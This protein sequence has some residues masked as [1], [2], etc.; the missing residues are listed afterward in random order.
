MDQIVNFSQFGLFGFFHWRCADFG[1][2]P[3]FA[4]RKSSHTT[5]WALGGRVGTLRSTWGQRS[6]S[7]YRLM[8][9]GIIVLDWA[10]RLRRRWGH[11][12]SGLQ[13]GTHGGV[14][15]G[16]TWKKNNIGTG[17]QMMKMSASHFSGLCQGFRLLQEY[18]YGENPKIESERR[19]F[20]MS[21][22]KAIKLEALKNISRQRTYHN[23]KPIFWHKSWIL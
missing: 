6:R 13:I 21:P 18:F 19:S 20:F 11:Q 8:N 23:R 5:R 2:S 7:G 9:V 15:I 3:A 22:S 16:S 14:G 17:D 10:D 12:A 4:R 1:K